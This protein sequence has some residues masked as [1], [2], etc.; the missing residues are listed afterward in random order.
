MQHMLVPRLHL[1][2]PHSWR[3]CRAIT[4]LMSVLLAQETSATSALLGGIREGDW[5]SRAPVRLSRGRRERQGRG[6]LDRESNNW[7]RFC[8]PL[9]IRASSDWISS[10]RELE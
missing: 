1:R 3:D 4:E 9:T 10:L 8:N 7:E 5:V 2:S 6:A